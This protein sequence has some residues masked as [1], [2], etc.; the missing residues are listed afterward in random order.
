[1]ISANGTWNGKKYENTNINVTDFVAAIPKGAPILN[2]INR[3]T[4]LIERPSDKVQIDAINDGELR[5]NASISMNTVYTV[6]DPVTRSRC[7]F[8][9]Y[10]IDYQ[11]ENGNTSYEPTSIDILDYSLTN[12]L[13][14]DNHEKM[15]F[16]LLSPRCANSPFS[17]SA[18]TMYQI[19]DMATTAK[20]R[21]RI[22]KELANTISAI[23]KMEEENPTLLIR[24]AQGISIKGERIFIA[25]FTSTDEV[26]TSLVDL[27][28]K[29]PNEFSSAFE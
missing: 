27:A 16:V 2:Y 18:K 19:R 23:Y 25:D 13:T 10:E 24:K 9:Y 8:R 20:E 29:F 5:R 17:D 11:L 12:S 14:M 22:D 7:Q 4:V 6:S 21:S 15:V 3:E 28:R 1:M 26:T